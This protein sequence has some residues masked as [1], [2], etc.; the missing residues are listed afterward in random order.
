MF[1]DDACGGSRVRSRKSK[2][3]SPSHWICSESGRAGWF[4]API[5]IYLP[6]PLRR[7]LG[8][9]ELVLA[10]GQQPGADFLGFV[11]RRWHWLA[12]AEFLPDPFG[13]RC[14]FLWTEPGEKA[15]RASEQEKVRSETIVKMLPIESGTTDGNVV[16]Y[17]WPVGAQSMQHVQLGPHH[18]FRRRHEKFYAAG[19]DFS[20]AGEPLDVDIGAMVWHGPDDF[21]D[22]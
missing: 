1:H 5:S 6:A 9:R 19:L 18:L 13:K 7:S 17:V 11:R 14:C 3:I 12:H 10:V 15:E 21:D 8:L 2:P 22:G 4:I 20:P 16:Q